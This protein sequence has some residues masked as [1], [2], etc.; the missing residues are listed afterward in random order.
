MFCHTF[1]SY[2]SCTDKDDV[3][4]IEDTGDE[5]LPHLVRLLTP[6]INQQ[7]QKLKTNRI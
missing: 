2:C 4:E 7:V 6:K 1:I 3:E 5:S